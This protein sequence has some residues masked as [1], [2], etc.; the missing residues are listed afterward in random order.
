MD[1]FGSAW[2][3]RITEKMGE[4]RTLDLEDGM[5]VY[6]VGDVARCDSLYITLYYI[7]ITITYVSD[8][9]VS[10]ACFPPSFRDKKDK[11]NKKDKLADRRLVFGYDINSAIQILHGASHR[12]CPD[13]C[14]ACVAVFLVRAFGTQFLLSSAESIG[15]VDRGIVCVPHAAWCGIDRD[16]KSRGW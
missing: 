14:G 13:S 16:G 6:R 12:V 8:Q 5:R 4:R 3:G 10:Y 11:K 15:S 7:G 1:W 2:F 9:C